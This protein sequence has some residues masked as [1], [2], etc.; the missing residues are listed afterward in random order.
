MRISSYLV[1]PCFSYDTDSPLNDVDPA[2]Y[3]KDGEFGTKN[4]Y[5]CQKLCQSVYDCKF[6][7]FDTRLFG[8]KCWLK[9]GKS[10]ILPPVAGTILGPKYCDDGYHAPSDTNSGSPYDAPPPPRDSYEEPH[11]VPPPPQDNYEEPKDNYEEP[12]PNYK[13]PVIVHDTTADNY[14]EPETSYEEP[15]YKGK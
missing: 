9:T 11:V 10:F 1:D 3:A 12:D 7:V 6:F 15:D 13:E 5:E 4:I 8:T 14:R 2:P